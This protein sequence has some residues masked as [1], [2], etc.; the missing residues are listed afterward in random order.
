MFSQDF[1]DLQ[2]QALLKT[3]QELIDALKER[4]AKLDKNVKNY[5]DYDVRSPHLS[6]D[7][8]AL[9]LDVEAQEVAGF[10]TRIDIEN[11]FEEKLAN[12]DLALKKLEAGKYGVCSVCHKN[13]S[14]SR[15]QALPE[16]QVCMDCE[17]IPK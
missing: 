11:T 17:K 4:D 15:L 10:E 13:I 14:E 12:I 3:K 5:E 16:A 7:N 8:E 9:D 6:K 2:K 1:L